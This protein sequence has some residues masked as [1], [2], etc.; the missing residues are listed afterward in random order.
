MPSSWYLTRPAAGRG[1]VVAWRQPARRPAAAQRA[2]RPQP[3]VLPELPEPQLTTTA[4]P[5]PALGAAWEALTDRS[6]RIHRPADRQEV[7]A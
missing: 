6:V 7:H 4:F 2:P 3:P 5:T 1:P